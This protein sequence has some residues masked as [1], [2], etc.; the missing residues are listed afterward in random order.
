[1]MKIKFLMVPLLMTLTPLMAAEWSS[2]SGPMTWEKAKAYCSKKNMRLP[3]SAEFKQNVSKKTPDDWNYYKN[4]WVSDTVGR[5]KAKV[6][7]PHP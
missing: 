5:T 3:S 2:I 1:M 4:Y 6:A 7:Q